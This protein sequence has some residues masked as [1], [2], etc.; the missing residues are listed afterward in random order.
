M[1]RSSLFRT[2]LVLGLI[3]LSSS[4]CLAV[5]QQPQ[6]FTGPDI[7]R[8]FVRIWVPTYPWTALKNRVAGRGAYRA[9]VEADGKVTKVVVIK[10]AGLRE[11]DDSVIHSAMGWRARAG[12]KR[13]I[14]FPMAFVPPPR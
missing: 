9:Y 8:Y 3:M 6:V 13:E 1:N 11:L 10:S 5:R 2:G 14:D 7:G 4:A 12:K